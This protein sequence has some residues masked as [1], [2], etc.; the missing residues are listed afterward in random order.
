ML[1]RPR[2]EVRKDE[3]MTE[4]TLEFRVRELED[5]V[6]DLLG[7]VQ[8]MGENNRKTLNTMERLR[9]MTTGVV[10]EV[11]RIAKAVGVLGS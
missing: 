9:D 2:L 1:L 4:P 6:A 8:Q 5:R 3:G 7:V 10:E 11:D